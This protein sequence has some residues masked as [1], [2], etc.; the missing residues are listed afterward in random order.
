M[1]DSTRHTKRNANETS[2]QREKRLAYH[3]EW[4]RKFRA[5]Y[6]EKVR[7][8]NARFRERHKASERQR[9]RN[10]YIRN[11]DAIIA[12]ACEYAKQNRAKINARRRARE[13]EN[14]ERAKAI[15]RASYLRCREKDKSRRIAKR[16]SL[17]AYMRHKRLSDPSFLVADRLRRRVNCAIKRAGA[18]KKCSLAEVSGC[19]VEELVSHIERQFLPGM[20]WDNR[21]L[22]H[23]DHIIPCSAF[24]L[25][26][27][28][29]QK[30]AFHYSNLRP[31][32]ATD[33]HRKHA[34]ILDGQRRLFWTD[35]DLKRMSARGTGRPG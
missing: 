15:R 8:A 2:E 20:S 12:N 13:R 19:S 18:N 29:Q 28:D 22:W 23:I 7:E 21:Q 5:K 25:T 30:I 33:N 9:S 16:E 34:K 31:I 32:W 26:D 27:I 14:P 4:M 3:R 17:A 24:N 10:N 6:P 35:A 11:R 1:A